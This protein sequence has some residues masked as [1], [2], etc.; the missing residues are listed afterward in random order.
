M[1]GTKHSPSRGRDPIEA[2]VTSHE[3]R[4]QHLEQQLPELSSQVTAV[5]AQ[6][7]YT[8][9][10]LGDKLDGLTQMMNDHVE[11][12]RDG[13]AKILN[14]IETLETAKK[15]SVIKEAIHGALAKKFLVP[16]ALTAGAILTKLGEWLAS[17]ITPGAQP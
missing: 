12:A 11:T 1:A 7:K 10:M 8:G 4:I 14:R 3:A 16:L 15:T 2:L 9:E 5:E 17:L 6:V 13:N